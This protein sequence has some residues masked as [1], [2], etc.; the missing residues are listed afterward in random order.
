MYQSFI[1]HPSGL[2]T[3]SLLSVLNTSP[4]DYV[5][6]PV[7]QSETNPPRATPVDGPDN[8][9]VTPVWCK[10]LTECSSHMTKVPFGHLSA[11]LSQTAKSIRDSLPEEAIGAPWIGTSTLS[12]AGQ[13]VFFYTP[14]I[15]IVHVCRYSN[16]MC[17]RDKQL[18]NGKL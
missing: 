14:Q 11:P 12:V 9:L 4:R 5:L 13:S 15:V 8:E 1:F 6:S 17:V 18:T 7:L 3:L 2:R 16:S 10:N